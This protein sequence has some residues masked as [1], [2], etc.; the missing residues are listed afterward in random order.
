MG[1]PVAS[2]GLDQDRGQVAL[3][4]FGRQASASARSSCRG[5]PARAPRMSAGGQLGD[6]PGAAAT[7][8]RTAA[9]A[10]KKMAIMDRFMSQSN[11]PT[12]AQCHELRAPF[13]QLKSVPDAEPKISDGP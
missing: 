13:I 1:S 12:G 11:K 3:N 7:G 9:K 5:P 6:A 2:S 4:G 10:S 8:T